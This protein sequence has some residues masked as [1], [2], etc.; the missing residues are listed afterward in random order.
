MIDT[1]AATTEPK[2]YQNMVRKFTS[3]L[4]VEPTPAQVLI[5]IVPNQTHLFP[6]EQR[7]NRLVD[8]R[9]ALELLSTRVVTGPGSDS[10][11]ANQVGIIDGTP[12]A[13]SP[14]INAKEL[15]AAGWRNTP[16]QGKHSQTSLDFINLPPEQGVAAQDYIQATIAQFDRL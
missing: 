8:S 9:F 6:L 16:N 11:P 12:Y 7:E 4:A 2:I 1:K 10:R 3:A 13:V 15:M 5:D 14:K